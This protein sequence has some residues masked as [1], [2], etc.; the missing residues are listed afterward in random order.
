MIKSPY[1]NTKKSYAI[2]GTG[3]IGGYCAVKLQQA[4]FD[5]HCLLGHDYLSVK[6]TGLTIIENDMPVTVSVNAYND[7][8]NMPP[9]DVILITLKTTANHILKDGL[10]N[11]AGKNI[12]IAMLQNGIG[13]EA[14]LAEFIEPQ[15]IVGGTC[16]LKV[17]KISPG[18]I[19]HFGHGITEWAQYF[20]D[21]N[22]RLISEIAK[23]IAGDFKLAGFNS[24]ASPHLPTIKWKKIASNIPISG[25]SVVLNTSTKELVET[26]S[27]LDLLKRM[28]REVIDAAK[29]CGAEIPDDFYEFRLGVF[30]SFKKMQENYPSMKGDFDARKPLELHAIYENAINIAK[31]HHAPMLLSEMLYLQLCYLD[32]KN[33]A[34]M[35]KHSGEITK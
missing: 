17:T 29:I 22:K 34:L 13:M 35:Q 30:E 27:S 23:E 15:K 10:K 1:K 25:L 31:K 26:P 21:E 7:I 18:T 19:R 2:I 33:R 8:H 6:E 32:A 16:I 14:E 11:M 28:T 5:V 3:A 4:G 20:P 24:T 9:C 12:I